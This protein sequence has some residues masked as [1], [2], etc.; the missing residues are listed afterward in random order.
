MNN[1]I[2]DPECEGFC[3]LYA[4]GPSETL[5]PSEYDLGK[6]ARYLKEKQMK[7]AELTSEELR[8]FKLPTS[9]H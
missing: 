5:P 3:G 1:M 7:Y 4:G 9:I 8:C 2:P 6:L